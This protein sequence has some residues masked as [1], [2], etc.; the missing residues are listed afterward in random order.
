MWV[1]SHPSVS[2]EQGQ[3]VVEFG[4][5]ALLFFLL[6]FGAMDVSR[7]VWSYSTMQ[8]AV[9]EASRYAIV[10]GSQS[11]IPISAGSSSTL[12]SIVKRYATSN[13]TAGLDPSQISVT[14]T[15]SDGD[16]DPGHRVTV[17]ATYVFHFSTGLFNVGSITLS[18]SSTRTIVH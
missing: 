4:L 17:A 11:S 15:W 18:A 5:V 2:R 14:A 6:V 8:D 3:A 13:N 10:H 16:N 12:T 1:R 7:A 9:Q